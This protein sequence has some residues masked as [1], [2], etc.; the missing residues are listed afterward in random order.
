MATHRG[1]LV[2][3]FPGTVRGGTPKEIPPKELKRRKQTGEPIFNPD[4][5]PEGLVYQTNRVIHLPED[6]IRTIFITNFRVKTIYEG[7]LVEGYA[8]RYAPVGRY[9][10]P[11]FKVLLYTKR[12]SIPRWI[13]AE[14]LEIVGDGGREM[15]I[16]YTARKVVD[17]RE[18]F[19]SPA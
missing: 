8:S 11:S 16:D 7:Q 17:L 19:R 4:L 13:P 3:D 9:G 14:A 15:D 5:L 18:K 6:A 1:R 12:G 2:Y 10:E